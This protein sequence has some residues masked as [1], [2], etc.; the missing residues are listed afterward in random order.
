MKKRRKYSSSHD[1]TLSSTENPKTLLIKIIHHCFYPPLFSSNI[2]FLFTIVSIHYSLHPPLFPSIVLHFYFYYRFHPPSFLFTIVSI[3]HHFYPSTI[4]AIYRRLRPPSSSFHHCFHPSSFP[5][6]LFIIIFIHHYFYP[7]F[8]S[9]IISHP[10]PFTIVS[11]FIIFHPPLFLSIV[12]IHHPFHP[13][14]FP[15]IIVSI[16]HYFYLP[17]FFPST[18]IFIFLIHHHFHHLTPD[19]TKSNLHPP[20][21]LKVRS[22]PY[23]IIV[24]HLSSLSSPSIRHCPPCTVFENVSKEGKNSTLNRRNE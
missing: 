14:L 6:F 11:I 16:H 5:S 20:T 9:V 4:V 15:S 21:I 7:S 12:S 23:I 13:P 22:S 3:Y 18:T 24:C 1:R 8:P 19:R 10:Y 2:I 17:S